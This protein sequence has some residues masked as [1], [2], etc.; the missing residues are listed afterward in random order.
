ML[1]FSGVWE[2]TP[3]I[4]LFQE[5]KGEE[6]RSSEGPSCFHHSLRL[7]QLK[8]VNMPGYHHLGLA[9]PEP[10]QKQ[11][12]VGQATWSLG[13]NLTQHDFCCLP[14]IKA[15]LPGQPKAKE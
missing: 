8:T 11:V 1:L 6:G 3:H 10:H 13:A 9:F 4:S 2:G 7:F 15:K 12:D 14:L 5:R